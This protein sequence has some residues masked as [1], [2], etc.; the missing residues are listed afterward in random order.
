MSSLLQRD[1]HHSAIPES[2]HAMPEWHLL[3]T[4]REQ[5]S[6]EKPE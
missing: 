3:N 5:V 1:L 2:L 6:E 4:L